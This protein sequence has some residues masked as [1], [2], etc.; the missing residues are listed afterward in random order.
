MQVL[1]LVNSCFKSLEGSPSWRLAQ[2][3]SQHCKWIT[4]FTF[5]LLCLHN[6]V[7]QHQL[8]M[9]SDCNYLGIR[10]SEKNSG[11]KGFLKVIQPNL[12]LRTRLISKSDH[13]RLFL[14]MEISQH[15]KTTSFSILPLLLRFFSPLLSSWSLCCCSG[16]CCVV[17]LSCVVL[18]KLL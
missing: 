9:Y 10:E 16:D 12:L 11:E 2:S 6:T 13:F 15:P 8:I 17:F 18:S 4:V 5:P 3:L 14:L 7:L 1:V